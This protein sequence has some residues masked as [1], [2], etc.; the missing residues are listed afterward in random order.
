MGALKRAIDEFYDNAFAPE[1]VKIM[2]FVESAERS[3]SLLA[4]Y[5]GLSGDAK[6][7]NKNESSDSSAVF[8]TNILNIRKTF[9]EASETLKLNQNHLIFIDGIDVRPLDITYSDYFGCVRGLNEAV[10]EMNND[11][12][13]NIKDSKGRLRVILP[14]RPNIFLRIGLHN[15]NTKIRDN[16]VFLDWGTSYK[17]YRES[18][19]FKVAD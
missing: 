2:N 5:R 1:I 15:V 11:Y 10:W 4:K 8:Q 9:E 19:L 13:A 7:V 16:T 14:V 3:W 12:F 6:A 18:S 17:Y